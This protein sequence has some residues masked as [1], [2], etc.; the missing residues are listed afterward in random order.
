MQLGQ[1]EESIGASPG[2]WADRG[3]PSQ[4]LVGLL[5]N[6]STRTANTSSRTYAKGRLEDPERSVSLIIWP[7]TYEQSKDFLA[8][9]QPVVI[10]GKVQLPEAVDEGAEAWD[11]VE[12][13]V[14]KVEPYAAPTGAKEAL[15]AGRP[16]FQGDVDAPAATHTAPSEPLEPADSAGRLSPAELSELLEG[17]L[18][19]ER[20][21]PFTPEAEDGASDL[22]QHAALVNPSA[23][24]SIL[25]PR[26]TW[27]V[28]LALVEHAALHQL[29]RRLESTRGEAEVRLLLRDVSGQLRRVLVGQRYFTNPQ[30]AD[31][32]L[33][34]FTFLR[35]ASG[36]PV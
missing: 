19:L 35:P 8:E 4:G 34:Q 20:A 16:S 5:T 1:L 22:G 14:D 27:E 23:L 15:L 36:L 7:K 28:D 10:W 3:I 25:G 33:R 12:I 30:D 2:V 18:P 17:G 32:L 11:G 9:N 31:A 13:V 24:R 29:A 6:L 26:I 21:L